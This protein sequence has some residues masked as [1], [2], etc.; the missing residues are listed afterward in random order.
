[1]DMLQEYELAD[2]RTC[3]FN[4]KLGYVQVFRGTSQRPLLQTDVIFYCFIDPAL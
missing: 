3:D 1:M 2:V 4:S